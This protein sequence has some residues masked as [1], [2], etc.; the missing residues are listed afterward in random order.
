MKKQ[1]FRSLLILAVL[2]AASS[3]MAATTIQGQV[4]LGEK[5][6]FTPSNKVGLLVS[7]TALSYAATAVHL[8]GTRQYGTVAGTGVTG[9]PS[10]IY[11]K[12]APTQT[13]TI[14]MP[15]APTDATALGSGWQ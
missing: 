11:W 10:K 15:T 6:S 2:G 8:T 4:T 12:D 7:S 9:D 1:V 3:A 5:G 14:G 13:G